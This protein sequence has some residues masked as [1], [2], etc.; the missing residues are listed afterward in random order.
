MPLRNEFE[1]EWDD[2][3]ERQIQ[4]I[5]LNDDDTEEDIELK[6][7]LL[8]IYNYRLEKREAMKK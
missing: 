5:E 7:R 2:I 6:M 3:C 8:E 4:D 1:C